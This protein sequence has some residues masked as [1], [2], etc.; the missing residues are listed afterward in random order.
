MN[1]RCAPLLL[2]AGALLGGCQSGQSV[3]S[4][5]A[6]AMLASPYELK[7]TLDRQTASPGEL[8]M[9]VIEFKNTGNE[10]VR[11]P[12]WGTIFFGFE[13]KGPFH[14]HSETWSSSSSGV[15]VMMVKPGKTVRY[16]KGFITPA[17]Y[18][19]FGVYIT[20]DRTVSAPLVI[21]SKD[22]HPSN[23]P[24]PALAPPATDQNPAPVSPS[25]RP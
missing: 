21:R 15:R 11:I 4:D 18:G 25:I 2:I 7:I 9:A 23:M 22:M 5:S 3:G 8:V 13:R 14:V 19:E 16:E 24:E 12:S 20:E 1:I 17:N 10:R 6:A